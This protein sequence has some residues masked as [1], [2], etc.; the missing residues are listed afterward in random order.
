MEVQSLGYKTDL[1]FPQFDGVVI[2][3]DSYKVILTPSN[4]GFYW[5]NFIL[6]RDAPV[7]GDLEA[8]E[9]VFDTEIRSRLPA[10]HYTFGW[11]SAAG[12]IGNSQEFTEHGYSLLRGIVLAADTVNP[13]PKVNREAEIRP[14]RTEWEWR[15]ALQNQ[16][17]CRG[18]DFSVEEYLPFKSEQMARYRRMSDAGLGQWFGAFC[19][20]K[21]VADLGIFVRDGIA[22]FQSVGTNPAYRRL[23]LCGTLVY[24]AS[25]YA[26]AH[27]NAKTLVMVA[28]EDYFA[29][30]IY[31]SVGFRPRERQVGLEKRPEALL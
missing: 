5:G 16:V 8:W 23:G 4:P 31:E 1:F 2:D 29:A 21:L 14:L 18:D 28:D 25:R 6:F 15:Q 17:E 7:F 13:P 20:G 3:R 26:F 9:R 24:Q 11:D 10:R 27:M 30:A 22:R 19:D 12:D